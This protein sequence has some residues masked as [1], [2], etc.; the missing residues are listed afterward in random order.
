MARREKRYRE[1]SSVYRICWGM[2]GLHSCWVLLIH[3]NLPDLMT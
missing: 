2:Q 3:A 1:V